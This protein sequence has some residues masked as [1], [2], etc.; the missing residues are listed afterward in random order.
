MK[1]AHTLL[2][3]S[4]NHNVDAKGRVFIP[5]KWRDDLGGIIIV[6]RGILGKDDGRCLFGMSLNEWTS[7]S[8]KLQSVSLGK[9]EAQ[10]LLR[11][12]MSGASECERDGQGRILI[13]SA[14]RD[15]A[16]IGD[17]VVLCG[18]GK[19]IEIWSAEM[20]EKQMELGDALGDD[21]LAELVELGI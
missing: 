3:N 14:L 8:Q 1:G 12:M 17:E 4:Y 10:R 6:T 20:W 2:I 11:M 19:R 9:V 18:M 15:Y 16:G 7:F 21:V 5:A 13:S